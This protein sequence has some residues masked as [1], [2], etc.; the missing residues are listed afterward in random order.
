MPDA[1]TVAETVEGA[2]SH[3]YQAEKRELELESL[4]NDEEGKRRAANLI[5]LL[6]KFEQRNLKKKK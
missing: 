4:Q 1:G 5:G 2:G 6:Q 3:S